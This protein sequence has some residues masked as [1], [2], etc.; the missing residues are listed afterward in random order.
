MKFSGLE[1]QTREKHSELG[2]LRAKRD[3]TDL[4]KIIDWFDTHDPFKQNDTALRCISCGLTARREDGIN[5]EMA[6]EADGKIHA[7]MDDKCFSEIVLK[8]K[9]QV[10][11][12]IHLQKAV[13]MNNVKKL[14]ISSTHLLTRLIV[15]VE[16]T[17]EMAP[18][19]EYELTPVPSSLFKYSFMRKPDKAALGKLLFKNARHP[20]LVLRHVMLWMVDPSYTE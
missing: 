20:D 8:K 10:K 16:R 7:M 14:F 13:V 11:K 5:C 9:S 4:R 2:K 18:F 12:L 3:S 15:L 19:F 6:D 17:A 1:N